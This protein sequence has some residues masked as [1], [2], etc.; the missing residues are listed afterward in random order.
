MWLFCLSSTVLTLLWLLHSLL[1]CTFWCVILARRSPL[2]PDKTWE[3]IN[4]L[5]TARWCQPLVYMLSI[6]FHSLLLHVCSLFV[7]FRMP[8]NTT[9]L[10]LAN[11]IYSLDSRNVIHRA[12]YICCIYLRHVINVYVCLMCLLPLL[13]LSVWLRHSYPTLNSHCFALNPKRV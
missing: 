3:H 13:V 11:Y 4:H 5:L 1:I 10:V 8:H 2:I 9:M 7:V 12:L 6:W